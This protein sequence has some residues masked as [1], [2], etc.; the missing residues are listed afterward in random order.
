MKRKFPILLFL[1][2]FIGGSIYLYTK[3]KVPPTIEF[4]ELSLTDL[5]NNP[6]NL[7]EYAGKNIFISFWAPWC[8]DCINEMPDLQFVYNRLKDENFV[9]LAISGYD[10]AKEKRYVTKNN[11]DITFLH[12]TQ[13]LKEIDIYSIPTNYI[14]NQKGKVVYEKVGAESNWRSQETMDKILSLIK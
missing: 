12:M 2:A 11:F 6:V 8:G 3:Y 5:N 1:F 7:S 4:H 13:K 9:F 14:I 10:I